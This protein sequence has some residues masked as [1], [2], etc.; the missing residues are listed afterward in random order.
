MHAEPSVDRIQNLEYRLQKLEQAFLHLT[1]GNAKAD[2]AD[3]EAN[4]PSATAR[5]TF[6]VSATDARLNFVSVNVYAEDSYLVCYLLDPKDAMEASL[7]LAAAAKK[8]PA[9]ART[10]PLP[11]ATEVSDAAEPETVSEADMDWP[12]KEAAPFD[13]E[14]GEVF[15]HER[16]SFFH[17]AKRRGRPKGSKNKP[18]TDTMPAPPPAPSVLPPP[19]ASPEAPLV[20]SPT[21]ATNG[22][23]PPHVVTDLGRHPATVPGESRIPLIERAI[24]EGLLPPEM[25]DNPLEAWIRLQYVAPKGWFQATPSP[26]PVPPAPPAPEA[27]PAPPKLTVKE[28][29]E[30][31]NGGP[32]PPPAQ[33]EPENLG[34]LAMAMAK[35]GLPVSLLDLTQ[36]TPAERQ[37][38]MAWIRG[39][40]KTFSRLATLG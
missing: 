16:R 5:I 37:E 3:L 11:M 14:T 21:A 40:A 4:E 10:L 13:P 7:Q 32:L 26:T 9:E 17:D 24:A 18:K 33:E 1:A 19:S 28:V 34:K 36:W 22:A 29:G 12:S 2:R 30:I 39:E 38:A 15:E 25:A 35:I 31:L 8:L 20:P 6:R 23:I 27:P